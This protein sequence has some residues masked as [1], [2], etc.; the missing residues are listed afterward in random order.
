MASKH[1]GGG[2]IW[3]PGTTPDPRRPPTQAQTTGGDDPPP[4]A[5]PFEYIAGRYRVEHPLGRTGGEATLY[6][7][8][9]ENLPAGHSD[10][11]VVVKLYRPELKPKDEVIAQLRHLSHPDLVQIRDTGIWEERFFEILEYCPGG[12]MADHAPYTEDALKAYLAQILEGLHYCHS[13]RPQ[14][15]HRDVKPNNLLFRDRDHKDLVL[16]DFGISS[17]VE[18]PDDGGRHSRL[19]VR[20]TSTVGRMTI[21]YTAPELLTWEDTAPVTE[22]V[23]YYSLGI[24]LSHLLTGASPFYA[25]N[26]HQIQ[27]AHLANKIPFPAGASPRFLELLRGLTQF[28]AEGRWGYTQVRQWLSGTA[29]RADEGHAGRRETVY[30]RVDRFRYFPEATNPRELGRALD[31]FTDAAHALADGEIGAWVARFDK[32]LAAKIQ[33]LQEE[34]PRNPALAV[35]KLAYLLDPDRRLTVD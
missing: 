14:I 27:A 28:D 2:G 6:L 21:D 29:V 1:A 23:D 11:T 12:S 26:A 13:L 30:G 15:V 9:D 34:C 35:K 25:K 7:C 17:V 8:Q 24:T 3:V 16:T 18:V 33:V 5:I 32:E 19:A 31:R 22:K 4:A 10:R 20:L